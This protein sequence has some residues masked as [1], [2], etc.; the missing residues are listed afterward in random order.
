VRAALFDTIGPARE[1]L[2]VV[3]LPVPEPGPR[4]VLVRIH[5]SSI[6]PSDLKRRSGWRASG[7]L[8]RP[9]IPHT[10]GAGV[11]EAIGSEVDG[12]W[13]GRRVWLWNVNAGTRPDAPIETGTAAYYASVPVE[14]VVPLPANVGFDVGACLGIPASTAHYAV[15]AD[16]DIAGK[17]V[18]VRGGAGAVGRFAVQFARHAGATVVASA[19]TAEKATAARQAGAHQAVD[20]RSGSALDALRAAAPEGFDRIIEVDFGVN[21]REDA[22]VLKQNGTIVSYSS[23]SHPEPV[24]PYYPLQMKGAVIRLI[25]SY[26]IPPAARQKAVEE[27]NAYLKSDRLQ[28]HIAARFSLSE[29]AAAHELAETGRV[30]GKVILM[31]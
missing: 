14:H 9:V 26:N 10:D 8:V 24:L 6:N 20:D 23:T 30:I 11:I 28:A 29:I 2:R 19:G 17:T 16:G 5:A 12:A 7:S 27:I 15:Y 31:I 13:L 4:D 22:A 25:T 18:L 1:V 21:A 3:E